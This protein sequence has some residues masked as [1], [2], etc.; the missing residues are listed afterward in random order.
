MNELDYIKTSLL[1]C[2]RV[3]LYS[4]KAVLSGEQKKQF[5]A[6]R[7]RRLGG[8]PLQY[9]FGS[10]EFCGLSFH[11]DPRVLIPRPETEIMVEHVLRLFSDKAYQRPL[12]VLDAGTGSGCVAVSLARFSKYVTCDAVDISSEALTVARENARLHGV[13]GRVSFLQGDIRKISLPD[14]SYDVIISNPPYIPDNV[15][16][17]L[18]EEV[19]CEPRQ[20]LEGGKDGLDF[21]RYFCFA[22]PRLL[23]ENG[24]LV[25]EFWDEQDVPIAALFNEPWRME[26]FPDL[27][28]VKRYFI[29]HYNNKVPAVS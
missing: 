1:N 22:A 15:I 8:E 5:D 26:F 17:S 25:C 28:G 14:H 3:D 23:I 13:D 12:R 21:Y 2:A 10:V 7:M 4:G 19:R 9:I 29:G 11:V 16:D 6:I 20:A 18:P 27:S 24:L